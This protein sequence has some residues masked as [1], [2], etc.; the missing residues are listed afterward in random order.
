[1]LLALP[2]DLVEDDG[3]PLT[4]APKRRN[5]GAAD[6]PGPGPARKNARP[7]KAK[8]ARPGGGGGGGAAA[9][10]DKRELLMAKQQ[11]LEAKK[12]ALEAAKRQQKSA[13]TRAPRVSRF[14][15]PEDIN[16][17]DDDE[18]MPEFVDD[19][20]RDLLEDVGA[21]TLGRNGMQKAVARA[22]QMP[23][24]PRRAVQPASSGGKSQVDLDDDALLAL[25][26]D[27]D[28]GGMFGD[29][30]G[31][32]ITADEMEGM[33][34]AEREEL[35]QL[36]EEE[37]RIAEEE[38]RVA[39]ATRRKEREQAEAKKRQER[40]KRE[41]EQAERDRRQRE[42]AAKAAAERKEKMER[43]RRERE[44]REQQE[45]KRERER[46]QR[47]ERERRQREAD[48]AAKAA[49]AKAAA[50]A[51]SSAGGGALAGVVAQFDELAEQLDD[52]L[53]QISEGNVDVDVPPGS[54]IDTLMD[55]LDK[56]VGGVAKGA[57]NVSK[58]AK[59]KQMATPVKQAVNHA[60]KAC[61]FCF[62]FC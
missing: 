44:Q 62:L 33:S 4:D 39:E 51:S 15:E 18:P 43:E 60:V 57:R 11:A 61:T 34:A 54:T 14:N 41:R 5:G 59:A 23:G 40:E 46:R 42:T 28:G 7:T 58:V 48:A 36:E 17:G 38:R 45:Q 31:A 55:R 26:D 20:F 22:K 9:A 1:M 25:L 30:F 47:E 21:D 37:R 13:T 27:D 6:R 56:L 50:A 32:D 12:A 52:C 2:I 24:K 19:E 35:R 8:T 10:S 53:L 29:D 3:S 49:A 16:G